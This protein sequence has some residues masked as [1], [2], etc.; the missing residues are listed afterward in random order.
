M[1]AVIGGA[2]ASAVLLTRRQLSPP[3]V[4]FVNSEKQVMLRRQDCIDRV[5]V[6]RAFT[7]GV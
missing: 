7:S 6:V 5:D 3:A 2:E 1:L 4:R